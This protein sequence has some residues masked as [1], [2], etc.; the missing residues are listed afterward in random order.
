[1]TGMPKSIRKYIRGEKARIHREVFDIKEQKRLI[2]ELYK[3]FLR[4]EDKNKEVSLK[5]VS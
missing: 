4:A 2:G 5:E 3:R 1:M